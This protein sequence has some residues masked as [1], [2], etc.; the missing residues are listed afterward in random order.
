MSWTIDLYKYLSVLVYN[1]M[2]VTDSQSFSVL[3]NLNGIGD[4]GNELFV[5]VLYNMRCPS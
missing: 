3:S 1:I 2:Q 5:Q 4:L